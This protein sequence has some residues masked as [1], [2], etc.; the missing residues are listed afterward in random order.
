M[1]CIYISCRSVSSF[2]SSFGAHIIFDVLDL[3]TVDKL[4]CWG[5]KAPGTVSYSTLV[6]VVT[7]C[8][9]WTYLEIMVWKRK[10][11][12]IKTNHF[13]EGIINESI[14]I[15]TRAKAEA[16]VISS[17]SFHWKEINLATCNTW[18]CICTIATSEGKWMP[19]FKFWI[20]I[21]YWC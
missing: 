4:P 11:V 6:L 2:G 7:S 16:M 9:F 3:P 5:K 10:D 14:N 17:R 8:S 12:A 13:L 15:H 1:I 21:T 19:G 18:N 20:E